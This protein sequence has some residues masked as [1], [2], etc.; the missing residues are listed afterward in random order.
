MIQHE[1]LKRSAEVSFKSEINLIP[2]PSA[3][4]DL[5]RKVYDI[6]PPGMEGETLRYIIVDTIVERANETFR[7]SSLLK[8]AMDDI[9]S[10]GADVAMALN[11]KRSEELSSFGNLQKF[12]C[13]K[14]G[15]QLIAP[16]AI[17]YW[18]ASAFCNKTEERRMM[19]TL[20]QGFRDSTDWSVYVCDL[21]HHF[22]GRSSQK[23]SKCNQCSCL[24]T[25]AV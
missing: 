16:K 14:C 12:H 7:E 19:N 18:C 21:G 17:E 5:A 9:A 13:N 6:S 4:A 2:S 8:D 22:F 11:S 3:L 20:P 1:Q 10:L 15:W 24:C 23:P 25:A